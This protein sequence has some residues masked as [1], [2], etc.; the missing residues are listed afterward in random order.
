M[1]ARAHIRPNFA[2]GG[3]DVAL[4]TE[5]PDG[6]RRIR[7]WQPFHE[8]VYTAPNDAATERSTDL[9]SIPDDEARAL[10][11]AL[12]EHYGHGTNDTR[13][14]RRDHDAERARVDKLTDALI[15]IATKD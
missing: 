1:T 9:L 5:L 14:L 4:V 10:Y 7:Q 15:T 13:D 8:T 6:A 2:L 3:I 11:E 12:A